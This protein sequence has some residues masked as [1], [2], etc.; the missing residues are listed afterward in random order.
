MRFTRPT[1]PVRRFYR[2]YL[3]L[4]AVLSLGL[5]ARMHG[6]VIATGVAG[7]L[8]P[9][10][11]A[12]VTRQ[13]LEDFASVR[14]HFTIANG[15]AWSPGRALPDGYD[16]AMKEKKKQQKKHSARKAKQQATKDAQ[17]AAAGGDVTSG[18]LARAAAQAWAA[19]K[20]AVDADPLVP[21]WGV[22]AALLAACLAAATRRES[23]ARTRLLSWAGAYALF[24]G[25]AF[26]ALEPGT[27]DRPLDCLYL[28]V[29]TLTTIGYGD[30][31]PATPHGRAFLVLFTLGGL[32]LFGALLSA[33][34]AATQKRNR[35]NVGGKAAGESLSVV[36][37]GME[38]LAA[39][40]GLFLLVQAYSGDAGLPNGP[41][42]ALY[43]ATVTATT[44]GFGDLSPKSDSG[45]LA[46]VAFS[47]LSLGT[48]ADAIALIASFWEQAAAA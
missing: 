1:P 44:V 38:V 33:A 48:I 21:Q 25:F 10:P 6:N 26:H 17:E 3:A 42:D 8:P 34:A 30:L 40:A 13:D 35:A 37:R 11:V 22:G 45:K 31:A 27:L 14:D 7:E 12:G 41:L 24:G 28:S 18:G 46:V 4:L 47:I 19:V 9:G 5:T 32:G 39:G 23:P 15:L 29:V 36:L 2:R 20:A 43:F 16:Q